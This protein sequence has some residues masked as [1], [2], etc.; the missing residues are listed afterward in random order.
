MSKR[1][2]KFVAPV[3]VVFGFVTV[4]LM[5]SELRARYAGY[6]L[7]TS[8]DELINGLAQS[9]PRLRRGGAYTATSIDG[10][11]GLATTLSN[12]SDATGQPERIVIYTTQM[13]DGSLFYAIGVAPTD[14]FGTYQQVFN[15]VVRSVQLNDN[16]RNSRY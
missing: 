4:A 6:Q 7:R 3:A 1:R 16:Q 10:H 5:W 12:V 11:R 8:T 9:N 13:N 15:R 14:E 2:F